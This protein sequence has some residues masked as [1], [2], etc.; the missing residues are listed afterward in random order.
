MILGLL[1]LFL[2]NVDVKFAEWLSKVTWGLY[3][4]IGA[5]P[6]TSRVKLINEKELAKAGLDKISETFV[7]YVTALDAMLI[8]IH[9]FWVV[10][11]VILQWDKPFTE[12]L[13]KN[14][15]YANHFSL[16]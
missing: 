9:R 8:S 1:F 12:D 4:V 10:Q 2:S 16:N 6:N 11:F 7:V 3:T 5:L 13:I 15:I 14:A